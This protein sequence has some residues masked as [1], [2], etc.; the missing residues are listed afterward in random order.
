M[1][2]GQGQDRKMKNK[3]NGVIRHWINERTNVL[4]TI[5]LK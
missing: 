3:T 5:T 1:E 2:M 4:Q